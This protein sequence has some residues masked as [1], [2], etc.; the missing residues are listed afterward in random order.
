MQ[1]YLNTE[2][3]NSEIT[4]I[5]KMEIQKKNNRK[6]AH[7]NTKYPS[8]KIR[9]CDYL[10]EYK[11]L[12]LSFYVTLLKGKVQYFSIYTNEIRVFLLK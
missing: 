8:R 4:K 11:L 2:P 5:K 7:S 9:Y 1:Q 12:T 10:Y 3:G 6:L